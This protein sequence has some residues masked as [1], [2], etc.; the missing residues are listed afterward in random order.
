MIQYLRTRRLEFYVRIEQSNEATVTPSK[1]K[2]WL[3]RAQVRIEVVLID[4]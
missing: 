4:F 1:L 3:L 2:L